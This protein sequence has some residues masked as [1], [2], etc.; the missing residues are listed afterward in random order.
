MGRVFEARDPD[1]GRVVAVKVI[2]GNAV[3]GGRWDRFRAEAETLARLNHPHIVPIFDSGADGDRRFFVM[4]WAGRGALVAHAERA[5]PPREVARLLILLARA[6]AAAHKAGVLHRDL[7]P[8]NVLLCDPSDEPALNSAWGWPKIADFGLAKE[9]EAPHDR[10][11]P[12]VPFGSP[13]YMAPEQV[14]GD[15]AAHGV[16]TDVYGLGVILYQMLAGRLPFGGSDL[17][18]QILTRTPEPPSASNAAVSPALDAICLKCLAKD[19]RDRYPRAEELAAALVRWLEEP[20]EAAGRTEFRV[21]VA[22]ATSIS[23]DARDRMGESVYRQTVSRVDRFF[24]ERLKGIRGVRLLPDAA[25]GT[26]ASFPSASEAVR[27]ALALH[28]AARSADWSG[29]SVDLRIAVHAGDVTELPGPTAG[30]VRP[31]GLAVDSVLALRAARSRIRFC[32]P[33]RCLMRAAPPSARTARHSPG[34]GMA[35]TSSRC[36]PRRWM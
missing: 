29:E 11:A 7:K 13:A 20:D 33:R 9:I 24:H 32:S 28:T 4:E 3:E 16:G 8:H 17:Y 22:A 31:F 26:L 5:N 1:L 23:L 30:T 27:T 35:G 10:T 21:L 2:L 19:P 34:A 14:R 15:L 36:C 12:G 18:I 6:I 25:A